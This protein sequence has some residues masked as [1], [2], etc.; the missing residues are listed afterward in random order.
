MRVGPSGR[1]FIGEDVPSPSL[2]TGILVLSSHSPQNPRPMR[3]ANDPLTS[4]VGGLRP[5]DDLREPVL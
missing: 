1:S 3:Y 4:L 2:R 5:T